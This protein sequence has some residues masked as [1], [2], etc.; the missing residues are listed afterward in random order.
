MPQDVAPNQKFSNDCK[1]ILDKIAY[2]CKAQ[3]KTE[4]YKGVRANDQKV[5]QVIVA[6]KAKVPLE[7]S[8][9]KRAKVSAGTVMQHL[10]KVTAGT[11]VLRDVQGKFMYEKEYYAFAETWAGGKL[12]EEQATQ[13]WLRM[14][15]DAENLAILWP[16]TD[17][18]GPKQS[19]FRMWIKT[20]TM[21]NFQEFEQRAKEL[22]SREKEK[23]DLS[24]AEI[25]AMH[26]R[27]LM[28]HQNCAGALGQHARTPEEMAR[29]LAKSGHGGGGSTG[30]FQGRGADIGDVEDLLHEKEDDNKEEDDEKEAEDD[31][32]AD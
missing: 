14:K 20:A 2:A 12:T 13:E 8:D 28:D 30:A 1:A 27:L 6:F 21:L 18:D 31:D 25:D 11:N 4:W 26:K 23:K 15:A 32:L 22:Q 24:Q 10:E 7:G 5:H 29:I 16:A 19:P 3:G 17:M 9:G